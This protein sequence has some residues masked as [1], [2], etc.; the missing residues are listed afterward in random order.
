M[1]TTTTTPSRALGAQ[2]LLRQSWFKSTQHWFG[3][4]WPTAWLHV[5]PS[6]TEPIVRVIAEAPTA[7]EAQGLCGEV[8]GMIR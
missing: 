1:A 8:G 7:G 4:D 6:N 2:P 5:R 3:R